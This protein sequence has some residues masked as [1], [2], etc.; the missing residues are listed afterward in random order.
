MSR[1]RRV[2]TPEVVLAQELAALEEA[3]AWHRQQRQGV[4]RIPQPLRSRL[5]AAVDAGVS[6]A[7]VSR[8]CGVTT[9]QIGQ[10]RRSRSRPRPEAAQGSE[11]DIEA[12]AIIEVIDEP[13]EESDE[14][15][16]LELGVGSWRVSIRLQPAPARRTEK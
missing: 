16:E 6:P 12:P 15:I 5:L 11:P 9:T 14:P 2:S 1:K 10:W 8:R 3:F 7:A 13:E 4:G